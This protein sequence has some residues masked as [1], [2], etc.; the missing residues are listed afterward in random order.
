MSTQGFL[1]DCSL[2]EIFQVLERGNKSGRLKVCIVLGIPRIPVRSYYIWVNRGH[3]VAAANRLDNR[4]LI[5]LF[6]FTEGH[7]EFYPD[8]VLPLQEMTGLTIPL[9]NILGSKNASCCISYT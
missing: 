9:S 8:A 4:G 7:F 3:L 6:K 2:P 5:L 1:S